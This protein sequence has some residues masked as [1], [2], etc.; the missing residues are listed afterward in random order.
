MAYEYA[1][2]CGASSHELRP[3]LNAQGSRG[4]RL[5]SITAL[6]GDVAGLCYAVMERPRSEEQ[7]DA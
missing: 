7:K 3:W 6:S 5:V 4:F 2:W 1:V